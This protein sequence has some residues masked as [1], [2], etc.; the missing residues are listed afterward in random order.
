MSLFLKLLAF[1]T[2]TRVLPIGGWGDLF[3]NTH[4]KMMLVK[5]TKQ[6]VYGR[7]PVDCPPRSS[8][9]SGILRLPL[10]TSYEKFDRSIRIA[11][12]FGLAMGAM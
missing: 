5:Y 4:R 11:I 10:Y 8:T 7:I 12:T 3:K 2:A 9:C 6:D 1:V